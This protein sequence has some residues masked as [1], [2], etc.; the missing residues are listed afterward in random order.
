M[1]STDDRALTGALRRPHLRSEVDR[2]TG[3]HVPEQEKCAEL[4]VRSSTLSPMSPAR[5]SSH[6]VET[7]VTYLNDR[8][9][10]GS[11]VSIESIAISPA[12]VFVVGTKPYKGLVHTRRH[13]PVGDLG[14][15]ELH[16]GRRNCTST[17]E[18]L[19]HQVEAVREALAGAP[20]ETGIPIQAVLCLTRA[21]WGFASPIEIGQVWIGWPRLVDRK[22][23]SPELM[24]SPTVNE[25]IETVT[26]LLPAAG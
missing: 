12:G 24:D 9:I 19:V 13:G 17:V 21:E 14:P 7:D 23:R 18:H 11:R 4:H 5:V 26:R 16:I 6:L 2:E 1:Q 25:A 15:V 3:L 8:R 10:P 22:L 20:W